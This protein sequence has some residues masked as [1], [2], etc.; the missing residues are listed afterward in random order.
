MIMKIYL[1]KMK[2]EIYVYVYPNLFLLKER[3]ML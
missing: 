3:Y 1:P 2:M